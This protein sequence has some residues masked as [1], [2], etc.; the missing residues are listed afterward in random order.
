MEAIRAKINSASAYAVAIGAG[1]VNSDSQPFKGQIV[2]QPSQ[3]I[4]DAIRNIIGGNGALSYPDLLQFL[5]DDIIVNNLLASFPELNQ[6][7]NI[8]RNDFAKAENEILKLLLQN[9]NSFDVTNPNSA[10]VT[11]NEQSFMIQQLTLE[12]GELKDKIQYLE[13]K[14]KQLINERIQEK[15]QEKRKNLEIS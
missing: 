8:F 12:N 2:N 6:F 1:T 15:M 5:V 13:D 9:V 7:M 3:I 10:Q 11:I 14:M 4:I